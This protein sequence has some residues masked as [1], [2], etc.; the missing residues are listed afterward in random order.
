MWALR[1]IDDSEGVEQCLE[2]ACCG[3]LVGLRFEPVFHCLLEAFDFAAGGGVVR[4]GMFLKNLV[5]GA[6]GF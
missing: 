4:F 3:R 2:F 5:F 6:V 1:V